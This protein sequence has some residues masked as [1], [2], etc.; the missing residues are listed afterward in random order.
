MTITPAIVIASNPGDDQI[1]LGRPGS[2]NPPT[3]A[4]EFGVGSGR[5]VVTLNGPMYRTSM[6]YIQ[7]PV[8]PYVLRLGAGLTAADVQLVQLVDYKG[9]IDTSGRFGLGAYTAWELRIKNTGDLIRFVNRGG[10]HDAV[11][12]LA[13]IEF[14]DGTSWSPQQVLAQLQLAENSESTL[15]GTSGADV[16]RGDGRRRTLLGADGDD[17]LHSGAGDETLR[18]GRGKNT[19]VIAADNGQDTIVGDDFDGGSLVQFGAGISAASVQVR[20]DGGNLYL[21]LPGGHSIARPAA[22]STA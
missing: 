12:Y 10:G 21:G 6:G 13:Q 2:T 22:R 11:P 5:D 15:Y 1:Y 16:L 4:L 3:V 7:D 20:R 19:Y 18:G 8:S 14:A 9:L 17:T